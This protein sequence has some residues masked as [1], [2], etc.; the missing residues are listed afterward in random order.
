[1]EETYKGCKIRVT[2][3]AYFLGSK[4]T[5]WHFEITKNEEVLKADFSSSESA[6]VEDARNWV[7]KNGPK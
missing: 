2:D 7:D 1:M 6:A 3:G 5:E 4:P